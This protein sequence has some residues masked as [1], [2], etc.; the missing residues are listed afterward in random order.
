M[1]CQIYK[2]SIIYKLPDGRFSI[3]NELSP[4]AK[5][6][7]SL[8]EAKAIAESDYGKVMA[9]VKAERE[10]QASLKKSYRFKQEDEDLEIY[11]LL[12]NGKKT[13]IAVEEFS[14]GT[15]AVTRFGNAVAYADGLKEA[16]ELAIEIEQED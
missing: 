5:F 1:E 10:R 12:K 2:A 6:A 16:K 9:K 11:V 15:Y 8:E 14:E 13:D 3:M 7:D 4:L